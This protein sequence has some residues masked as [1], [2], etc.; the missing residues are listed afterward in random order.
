MPTADETI[1]GEWEPNE[2]GEGLGIDV[3]LPEIVPAE[4]SGGNKK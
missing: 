3:A 4:Q 2:Q 1:N